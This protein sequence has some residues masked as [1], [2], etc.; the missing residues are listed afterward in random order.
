MRGEKLMFSCIILRFAALLILLTFVGGCGGGGGSTPAVNAAG[1]HPTNW[2]SAHRLAYLRD[3]TGCRECHG[4]ISDPIGGITKINCTTTCHEGGHLPRNE[5]H[6]QIFLAGTIHGPVAKI[7]L[8]YCQYCHGQ[9]GGAGSNP[10]FNLS[11]STAPNGCESINCHNGAA[12]STGLGHPNPWLGHNTSG[13]QTNACVLCHG[14]HY[15]GGS[16]PACNSCHKQ[17]AATVIPKL[18]DNCSSCHD[19]PPADVGDIN[20]NYP[21]NAGSHAKHT[22]LAGVTC[23]TC[24]LG[25]GS[26]SS[27]HYEAS[28][29]QLEHPVS[30]VFNANYDSK[31]GVASISGGRGTRTCSNVRCHGGVVTPQWGTPSIDSTDGFECIDCHESGTAFQTPEYNSFWSGKHRFHMGLDSPGLNNYPCTVCHLMNSSNH[32]SNLATYSFETIPTV[33]L[34][35]YFD[36]NGVSCSTPGTSPAISGVLSY[37]CHP[38]TDRYNW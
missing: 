17:L 38:T 31:Q 22:V 30:V 33:T 19:N 21:N 15:E 2:Y 32:F 34:R 20:S 35:S 12:L 5:G 16:G 4:V 26:G 11:I 10:R 8:I 29:T 13:N 25:T 9:P 36:Y 24:H 3:K 27:T 18:S 14:A 28:R 6:A 37:Q 1:K 23:Y 7:D